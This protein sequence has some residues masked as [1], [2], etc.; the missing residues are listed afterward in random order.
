MFSEKT[1]GI[2]TALSSLLS[3]LVVVI[4]MQ[5]LTFCSI[6]D[7][8]RDGTEYSKIGQIFK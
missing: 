8:T 1:L 6:S 3:S 2:A 5:K 7:L 4:V